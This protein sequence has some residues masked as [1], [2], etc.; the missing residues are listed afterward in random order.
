MKLRLKEI[1]TSRGMT[2]TFVAQR[3]GFDNVQPYHN[4]EKGITNL[5]YFRAKK[6][7]SI[8]GVSMEELGS[9]LQENCNKEG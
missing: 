2:Q 8:F 1:R 6:L 7:A 5:E 4:I 9:Q 3:M